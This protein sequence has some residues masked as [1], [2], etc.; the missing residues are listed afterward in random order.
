MV[1]IVGN[2]PTTHANLAFKKF[3]KL[4]AFFKLYEQ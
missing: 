1:L 3:I 2:A 4:L